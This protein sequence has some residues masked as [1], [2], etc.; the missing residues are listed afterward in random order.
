M[1]LLDH[2][3]DPAPEPTPL[4]PLPSESRSRRRLIRTRGW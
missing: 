3:D 1:I 2:A 4:P